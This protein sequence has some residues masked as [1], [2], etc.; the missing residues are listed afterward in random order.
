MLVGTLGAAWAYG[1]QENDLRF[2][3]WAMRVVAMPK[4]HNWLTDDDHSAAAHGIAKST[5]YLGFLVE[6]HNA[7]IGNSRLARTFRSSLGCRAQYVTEIVY[8]S[9]G[10]EAKRCWAIYIAFFCRDDVTVWL[11]QSSICC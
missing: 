5:T 6:W 10:L 11:V 1:P 3:L 8:E 9:I 7:S 4:K 2:P